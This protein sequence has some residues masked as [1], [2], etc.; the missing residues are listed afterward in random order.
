[1]EGREN[2]MSDPCLSTAIL[3]ILLILCNT[4]FGWEMYSVPS[5]FKFPEKYT[6]LSYIWALIL[7][8]DY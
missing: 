7:S 2:M 4:S 8:V 3:L 5:W 1:M 6:L